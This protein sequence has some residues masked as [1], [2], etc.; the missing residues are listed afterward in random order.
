MR[1]LKRRSTDIALKTLG[2]ILSFEQL[3]AAQ[4]GGKPGQK[5][6]NVSLQGRKIFMTPD[7]PEIRLLRPVQREPIQKRG[8]PLVTA[9]LEEVFL[10][11]LIRLLG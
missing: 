11:T 5:L 8:V 9:N 4:R 10:K 6:T 2:V 3:R 7:P 1:G